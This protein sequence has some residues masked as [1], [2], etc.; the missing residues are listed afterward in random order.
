MFTSTT[1]ND[2]LD[3]SLFDKTDAGNAI[4]SIVHDAQLNSRYLTRLNGSECIKSYALGFVQTHGDVAVVSSMQ[5]ES[6]PVLWTRYPQR[7]V[8]L[9]KA[10]TN[11]DA[12]HWI[13]HDLLLSPEYEPGTVSFLF[14]DCS[15]NFFE[16]CAEP[17]TPMGVGALSL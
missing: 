16:Y 9:D 2:V 6:N 3:L 12:F 17:A 5:N 13:C 15:P 8:T 10:K 11:S 1:E 4:A 14:F 7:S